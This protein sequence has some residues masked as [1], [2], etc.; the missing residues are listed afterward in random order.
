MAVTKRT[1]ERAIAKR[2][3]EIMPLDQF[4]QE[5]QDEI[6]AQVAADRPP[7]QWLSLGPPTPHGHPLAQIRSRA[8]H[9]WHWARGIDPDA[10]RDPLPHGRRDA[11]IARD[12]YICQICAG[13]VDPLDVH[14]DHIKAYSKGSGH[15]LTNLR[16]THSTCNLRKGARD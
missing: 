1:R 8:W 3:A 10:Q 6:A 9:E 4:S 12:G 13:E 15:E 11:V 5:K 7:G 14:I 2:R 16:V